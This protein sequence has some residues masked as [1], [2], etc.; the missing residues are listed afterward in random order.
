MKQFK[1][2]H[3][4]AENWS[5]I[6]KA[7][8]D[9]LISGDDLTQEDGESSLGFLY[10]TDTISDNIESILSYLR[11]TTGIDDWIGTTGIGICAKGTEYFDRPA[12]VAMVA[13]FPEKGFYVFPAI[14]DE[15]EELSG[16]AKK[17]IKN[18]KSP[19]GIIHGD[20]NNKN[21]TNII[22]N[23]GEMTSGFLVGGFTASRGEHPQI[24]GSITGSGVS[25]ALFAPSVE[26]AT[27]LTQGCLPV[28]PTHIVSDCLDN[29]IF[30]LNG[31]NALE[32]FKDDIG[33]LLSRDLNRASGYIHAAF[34]IEGSD[35][36]D[37]I[38][39]NLVGIDTNKGWLAV[40]EDIQAGDRLMFVR[41]D[42]KSAEEDLVQMLK[43]LKKRIPKEPRG[44][45]YFSCVARGP[46]MFGEEGR[47]LSIIQK[48]MGDC[49]LVGFFG[50]GEVSNNRV[51]GYTGVLVLFL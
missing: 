38:V 25:G 20:P 18:Q 48:I 22:K 24:A 12:A 28:G 11:Q 51:Y 32:I 46:N 19:F 31:K 49:P 35:T 50:N 36:G 5:S 33:E 1:Y 13:Q 44:G 23:L 47:E 15:I 4:D 14:L 37:Y 3:S 7:L 43:K 39:R 30:S 42:P 40:N 29:I 2:A 21:S 41:R 26:V 27:G 9:G 6:A 10:V 17:W 8:V 45:V 34:P 16:G